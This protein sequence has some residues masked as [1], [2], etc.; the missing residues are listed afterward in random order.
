M[1]KFLEK[2]GCVE[3]NEL[4]NEQAQ[5]VTSGGKKPA[6]KLSMRENIISWIKVIVSAVVIAFIL[7]TFFVVTATVMS[8]SMENTVM[9]GDSIVCNRLAYLF[10]EPERF[11]IIAFNFTEPH[12]ETRVY[13]KR[14]IALPG[15][16]V[17][18]LDGKVYIDGSSE[19]L[20]DDFVDPNSYSFDNRSP[21]EVPEGH[22]FVLG[23]NRYNS[24]DSKDWLYPYLAKD[25]ILGKAAFKYYP[26][27]KW[28][29]NA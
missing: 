22:Y 3:F 15:E 27:V 13:V 2:S 19:A 12:G 23:D 16:T 9:T 26:G 18:I 14:I 5:D 1:L 10:G 6:K 4:S 11:D 8:G 21:Y 28:L 25:D 17:E 29:G 24:Y 20:P 7:K